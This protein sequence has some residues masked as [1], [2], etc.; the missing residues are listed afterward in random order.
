MPDLLFTLAA[1][2]CAESLS[3]HLLVD[4]LRDRLKVFAV[5]VQGLK[6]QAAF[7]VAPQSL[8]LL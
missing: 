6:E 8:W 5:L 3:P 4:V 7:H 1:R 2:L